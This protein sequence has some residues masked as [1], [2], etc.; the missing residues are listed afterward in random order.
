[1]KATVSVGN[2]PPEYFNA[3][4]YCNGKQYKDVVLINYNKGY[5]VIFAKDK[6]GYYMSTS[7]GNAKK[8]KVYGKIKV[9]FLEPKPTDENEQQ[10]NPS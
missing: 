1:M 10:S 5:I 4:F 6:N 3:L 2:A 9:F 8:I 7:K